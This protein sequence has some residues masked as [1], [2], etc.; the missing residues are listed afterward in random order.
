M[1][2]SYGIMRTSAQWGPCS[3]IF[4]KKY[5]NNIVRNRYFVL[6]QCY[7]T[8]KDITWVLKTKYAMSFGLLLQGYPTDEIII[9]Q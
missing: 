1:D 6:R 8:C 3:V 5:N 2:A 4:C 7:L 9:H